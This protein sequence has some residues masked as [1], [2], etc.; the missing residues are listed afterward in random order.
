M[1]GLKATLAGTASLLV[2][3][4]FGVSCASR[5][6]ASPSLSS[7]ASDS[8]GSEA[9]HSLWSEADIATLRSLWIGSLPPLPPDPSNVVADDPRAAQLGRKFFFDTRL[10]ANGEV[11]CATC[12]QP[13]LLFTD[14]LARAEGIGTTLRGAPTIVG[15]AY[16]PWFYWDGRRDS[17][18]AQA[19]TPLEAGVEHG[20]T[21]THYARLIYQDDAYRA[22]YEAIFG[23]LPDLSY[24][25]RFP[26]KSGP[27]EDDEARAA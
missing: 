25:T 22:E 20:G 13:D 27:V 16:S 2:V 17:Q 8:S 7:Q 3:L 15:I 10:S 5:Q 12:H 21:R 18:W 24:S 11:S 1:P 23:P 9:S 26:Q 14:G 19:L 4:V 6:A